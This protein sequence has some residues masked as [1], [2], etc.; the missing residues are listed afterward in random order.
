MIGEEY[1]HREIRRHFTDQIENGVKVYKDINGHLQVEKFKAL[2]LKDMQ[3]VVGGYIEILY[4]PCK[5][6]AIICNE[7]AKLNDHYSNIFGTYIY[8][9]ELEYIAG[10]IIVIPSKLL[11]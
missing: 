2:T 4:S 3:K 5:K 11:K 10:D 6:Y 7:E 9:Q 8:D 1:E